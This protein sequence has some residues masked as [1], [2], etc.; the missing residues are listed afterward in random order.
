MKMGELKVNSDANLISSAKAAVSKAFEIQN[1]ESRKT[2]GRSFDWTIA[3]KDFNNSQWFDPK[4]TI[5]QDPA[6][7]DSPSQYLSM[8]ESTLSNFGEVVSMNEVMN[9]FRG[10][11]NY[12]LGVKAFL[13]SGIQEALAGIKLN[14][15]ESAAA[16]TIPKPLNELFLPENLK[17]P[18]P[19]AMQ[20]SVQVVQKMFSTLNS[21]DQANQAVKINMAQFLRC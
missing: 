15:N 12:Q 2:A 1:E 8:A 16:E 21:M 6:F 18:D 9:V 4:E 5:I 14:P 13:K 3:G 20:M 17:S 11:F 19:V 7:S 10:P